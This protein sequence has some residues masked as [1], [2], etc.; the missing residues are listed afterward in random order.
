[1]C[2]VILFSFSLPS[3]VSA[4]DDKGLENAI[5]TAKT[6]FKIPSDF[7]FNYQMSLENGKRIWALRWNSKDGTKGGI[8][9]RLDDNGVIL[10]YDN[11]KPTDSIT[12]KLPKYSRKDA[13]SKAEAFIKKVNPSVM[14]Q[15]KLHDAGQ[16]NS[17][18][19]YTYYFTYV[20]VVGKIPFY[21]NNVT[22]SINK[23]TGEVVGY[24]YNWTDGL[25]FP[26]AGKAI[27]IADAGKAYMK[28]IGLKLIYKCKT[29]NDK[30][31]TYPAYVPVFNDN[32][33]IDALTGDKVQT[34]YNY[35]TLTGGDNRAMYSKS[36]V[37]QSV[38]L[39]PD[40]IKAAEE[41]SKLI[42]QEEAEKIARSCSALKLN[43]EYKL[44]YINLNKGWPNNNDIYWSLNFSTENED[45]KV[46]G[47]H[48]GITINAKTGE[49]IGFNQSS[50]SGD[51]DPVKFDE[52]AA[53]DAVNEFLKSFNPEKFGQVEYY[54]STGDYPV[55][56]STED[57]RN[58][59]FIYNRKANG[60][61]FPDNSI[62]V[63]FD[64]VSGEITNYSMTWF[65]ADFA[66]LDKVISM[67]KAYE[68]A[69]SQ[70]GLELQYKIK[71][72]EEENDRKVIP[73]DSTEKPEVVLVYSLNSLKPSIL[74]AN[75][76]T[77]IDYDG[78]PFKDVKAVKYSDIKGHY[79]QKQI[80][81]LAEAGISLDGTQFKP[82]VRI[83]QKDFLILLSKMAPNYYGPMILE[84]SKTAD[85]DNFYSYLLGQ[86]VIKESEKAPNSAI[87]KEDAVK[88][89]IRALKYN[90]VAD[91]K[92]IFKCSFKDAGKI[93]P[94][95][96]GY[97]AIAQGLKIISADKKGNVNPKSVL[98]RADAMVMIYNYLSH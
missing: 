11:Y 90:E 9:I 98:T 31:T 61:Q 39:T 56:G 40:E 82:N 19:E 22:L 55:I 54:Q 30:I 74:D 26:A 36:K 17:I 65:D 69:F 62:T 7:N 53:K 45:A 46:P 35:I 24:D 57:Q 66:K 51:K 20:R 96:Y 18:S 79:A 1:M 15:I 71:D 70:I 41:A 59:N 6:M 23:N 76:G 89:F 86:N 10:G 12:Q 63:S 75:T 21:S 94:S 49:I 25:K 58:Y 50:S 83:T 5:K 43:D 88:L 87:T 32:F 33:A 44:T 92:G 14:S 42:T 4:A 29:V 68:K 2:L 93:T 81:V 97:F 28:N 67:G 52:A 64:A 47:K 85:V 27:S 3:F 84:S 60:I 37:D 38:T 13:Q 16:T 48:S 77:V 8:N 95:L 73:V 72:S 78:N 34:G 80:E 91:I